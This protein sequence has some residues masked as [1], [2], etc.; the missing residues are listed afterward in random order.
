MIEVL[1]WGQLGNWLFQYALGQR[2]SRT[3]RVPLVLNACRLSTSH[4][5]RAL[6]LLPHLARDARVV[7]RPLIQRRLARA[8][9]QAAYLEERAWGFDETFLA[10]PP[11]STLRGYFQCERYFES[12]DELRRTVREGIAGGHNASYASLTS[13]IEDA[14]SVC[15]HVRRGDYLSSPVH[16]HCGLDY[17]EQAMATM[18]GR[19][20]QPMFFVFSDDLAWCRQQAIFQDAVFVNVDG[21]RSNPL[22][23]LDLMVRCKHHIIANS[24]FS[25][26][27]AW[28]ASATPS[29]I[30]PST[31]FTDPAE[32]ALALRD[33]IAAGWTLCPDAQSS[34][35]TSASASLGSSPRDER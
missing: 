30:A 14:D 4:R 6:V 24:T 3:H 25:W 29:V 22:I 18:R 28:L 17:Y 32:N 26:W 33:T 21:A 1:L 19:V 13:Q 31:W 12:P 34:T 23:D 20:S 2:L 16:A 5:E 7:A 27:G 11:R 15:I 8:L 9:G 10:A 35:F